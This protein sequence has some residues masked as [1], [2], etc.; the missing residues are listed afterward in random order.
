M[1]ILQRRKYCWALFSTFI[2]GGPSFALHTLPYPLLGP[3]VFKK[4]L[5][6]RGNA[7][8]RQPYCGLVL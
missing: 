5:P 7:I 2:G 4:F 6:N 8:C 1:A 3:H